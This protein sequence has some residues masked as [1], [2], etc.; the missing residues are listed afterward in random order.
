MQYNLSGDTVSM[1]R[2]TFTSRPRSRSQKGLSSTRPISQPANQNS[3][4][5]AKSFVS[6]L[7]TIETRPKSVEIKSSIKNKVAMS[8]NGFTDVALE[9]LAKSVQGKKLE[10]SKAKGKTE[11]IKVMEEEEDKELTAQLQKE[12][13]QM[14]EQ[15]KSLMEQDDSK[16]LKEL[17]E[18][19]CV[20][21]MCLLYLVICL[22]CKPE[23]KLSFH[24]ILIQWFRKWKS[25]LEVAWYIFNC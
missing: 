16:D 13:M 6:T 20:L 11:S 15:M 5:D 18:Y 8:Q 24:L 2:F 1:N 3:N 12:L 7:S 25:D 22:N 10:K 14:K 17:S 21:Y 19:E 9:N 4:F 23:M